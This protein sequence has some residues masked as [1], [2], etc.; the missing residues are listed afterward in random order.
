MHHFRNE[1]K[2]ALRFICLVPHHQQ[3]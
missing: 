2:G 1:G 3:R